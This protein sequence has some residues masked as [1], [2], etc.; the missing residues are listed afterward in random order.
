MK[1]IASIEL[2]IGIVVKR[3]RWLPDAAVLAR[4]GPSRMCNGHGAMTPGG[5]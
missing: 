5:N 4:Y 1:E 3:H 2:F